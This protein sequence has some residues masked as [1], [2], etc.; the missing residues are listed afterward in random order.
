MKELGHSVRLTREPTLA[1]GAAIRNAIADALTG[2]GA[3]VTPLPG[4]GLEFHMPAPWRTGKPSPL[5]AV[6][7]GQVDVSA[8]AGAGRRVRY[9][10]SFTRLRAYGAVAVGL[11]AVVGFHWTRTAMVATLLLA[12]LVTFVVPRIIASLRFRRLVTAA[13]GSVV[14]IGSADTRAGSSQ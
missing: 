3:I 1:E 13:A 8:G 10:L 4:R 9:S 11:A 5:F 12:W 7:G 14:G 2:L 6:T